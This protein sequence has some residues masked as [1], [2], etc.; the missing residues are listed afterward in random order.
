MDFVARDL[1]KWIPRLI[2]VWR[3]ARYDVTRGRQSGGPPDRLLP[4]EVREV[5]AAIRR[6][7]RG[8]TRERELAGARYM[9]DPKLL[10]AYLLFYWPVSYAQARHVLKELPKTPRTV[11]DLGSGPGPVAFAAVDAGASEVTAADRS[12]PA[13]ELARQLATEA[14]EGL[15]TRSWNGQVGEAP[16]PGPWDVITMGHVLNELWSGKP[17]AVPR[18]SAVVEKALA[19]VRP[20]GSVVI[21]EPALR[22]TSRALLQLRDR[23]VGK[24]Y[25]V[26]APCM[27]Q[28]DCPALVKET[29]WCHAERSWNPPRLVLDLARAAGLHKE[30]LKMSYLV[31]APKPEPWPAL[32]DGRLFRIVS[33]PL[34]SKG[35]Q[36]YIGCGPEGRVGLSLQEKHITGANVDFSRLRRGDVIAV[37][38][39]EEKGDG[40]ALEPQSR[41]TIVARAGQRLPPPPKPEP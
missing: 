32:P 8:L 33:E 27:F 9:E 26:R 3:A 6:L 18:R 7:S 24:G 41:V 2:A 39:T 15:W 37:E 14:G 10:G 30:A 40:L 28:G 17:D 21:L 19:Q 16:P 31:L 36:R 4:H 34:A 38:G 23:L 25:A 29:D 22:D 11:L 1:N 20:G 12:E 13:L 5:G 35:R